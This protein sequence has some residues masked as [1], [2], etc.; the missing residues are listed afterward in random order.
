MNA[1]NKNIFIK[2]VDGANTTLTQKAQFTDFYL[3]SGTYLKLD[4]L[5]IGY[6]IPVK[7]NK[8]VQSARIYLT[9]QNLL[10]LTSYSGQDP[11]VNT[12]S[13]WNGGIDYCSFSPPVATF[14]V[15]LN[16]SLF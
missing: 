3:E 4:N 16:L 11:E 2:D 6:T 5:T 13:V 15:G 7:E 8:Y 9:G 12:T 14:L 10:T 1:N